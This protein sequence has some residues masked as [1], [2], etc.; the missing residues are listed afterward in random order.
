M[1][2]P[3]MTMQLDPLASSGTTATVSIVASETGTAVAFASASSLA[4]AGVRPA[5]AGRAR[6][7]SVTT[8][9]GDATVTGVL[10]S[11]DIGKPI[12]GTGIPAGTHVLSVGAT[13]FELTAN[14]TAAGTITA[15]VDVDG[16]LTFRELNPNAAEEGETASDDVIDDPAGTVWELKLRPASGP[17]PAPVYFRAPDLDGWHEIAGDLLT[18]RPGALPSSGAGNTALDGDVGG[19][20]GSNVINS[21]A[22]DEDKVRPLIAAQLTNQIDLLPRLRDAVSTM[23]THRSDVLLPLDSMTQP[24]R[25]ASAG[26]I[27]SWIEMFTDQLRQYGPVTSDWRPAGRPFG[28]TATTTGSVGTHGFGASGIVLDPGEY[29]EDTFGGETANP[30]D[31]VA[32]YVTQQATGGASAQVLVDGV[33]VLAATSTTNA[34]GGAVLGMHKLYESALLDGEEHTVRVV[35][36][37]SGTV[38]LDGLLVHHGTLSVGMILWNGSLS[39]SNLQMHLDGGGFEDHV[40]KLTTANTLAATVLGSGLA[41]YDSASTDTGAEWLAAAENTVEMLDTR[42]P[43]ADRVVLCQNQRSGFIVLSDRWDGWNEILGPIQRD[44]AEA[45]R[46]AFVD[47]RGALPT[48]PN[49][50]LAA[51]GVDYY[52]F[53]GPVWI[54]GTSGSQL[55]I[56]Y[57]HH[58]NRGNRLIADAIWPVFAQLIGAREELASVAYVVDALEDFVPGGG[59]TEVVA[60]DG[61]TVDDTDPEAPV[62]SVDEAILDLLWMQP[63]ATFSG[64]GSFNYATTVTAAVASAT[65]ITITLPHV[66]A[67]DMRDNGSHLIYVRQTSTG[68]GIMA[69]GAGALVSSDTT[70]ARTRGAGSVLTMA[71]IDFFGTTVWFVVENP[72]PAASTTVPGRVELATAAETAALASSTLVPTPSTLAPIVY[73]SIPR[74]RSAERY[75][76]WVA[77]ATTPATA[78]AQNLLYYVPLIMS[79]GTIDRLYS[80]LV[81]TGS[82]ETLRFGLFTSSNGRPSTLIV[83]AGTVSVAAGGNSLKEVTTSTALTSTG[84]VFGA[85]VHQG[86]ATATSSGGVGSLSVR[87]SWANPVASDGFSPIVAWTEAGVTGALPATAGTLA[88]V[89]GTTAVPFFGWRY[90]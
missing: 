54:V 56:D 15:T 13:T 86:G 52:T 63:T 88:E 30:G 79:A 49:V 64:S 57:T 5:S 48:L 80:Y 21:G 44:F 47:L 75:T 20:A 37:G 27:S 42:A 2:K 89:T 61:I 74:P 82:G 19:T 87:S 50:L 39:G 67:A 58:N 90:T 32:V 55:N 40:R 76:N 84:Q 26:L 53:E 18:S 35:A 77:A 28:R 31:A 4:V 68:V 1:A 34:T 60:G 73:S 51:N 81:A 3:T 17:T 22:V 83:D 72:E 78:F 36:S 24:W 70:R 11:A 85:F 59:T 71:A 66:D 29:W 8:V 45:N 62:V 10:R 12:T 43:L 69:A 65:D 33:Q 6:T 7:V 14:A 16:L 9:N 38:K 23:E 25:V 46:A 41:T